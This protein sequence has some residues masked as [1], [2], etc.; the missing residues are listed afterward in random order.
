MESTVTVIAC[1]YEGGIT[2]KP[3]PQS[4][5]P[6]VEDL[7]KK[8]KRAV[9]ESRGLKLWEEQQTQEPCPVTTIGIPSPMD[10]MKLHVCEGEICDCAA[11]Q[12]I[13][14]KLSR[15]QKSKKATRWHTS[16]S[17]WLNMLVYRIKSQNCYF[18]YEFGCNS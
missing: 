10:F 14:E 1:S 9:P 12:F 15:A 8:I 2:Y 7:I 13:K 11:N 3:I 6:P 17:N 18:F 16:N 5:L 4:C